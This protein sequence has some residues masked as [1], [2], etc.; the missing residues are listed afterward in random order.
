MTLF[1]EYMEELLDGEIHGF[2]AK[3]MVRSIDNYE[4]FMRVIKTAGDPRG[5]IAYGYLYMNTSNT[6][7]ILHSHLLDY[8][9][10]KRI[11]RRHITGDLLLSGDYELEYSLHEFLCVQVKNGKLY[12][13][14]SY[15]DEFY[16]KIKKDPTILKKYITWTKELG[17]PFVTKDIMEN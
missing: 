12:I 7:S 8:L 4:E 14:E 1:E 2:N 9:Y 11:L 10:K 5:V 15:T 6:R 3:S 16:D 13:G 17:I